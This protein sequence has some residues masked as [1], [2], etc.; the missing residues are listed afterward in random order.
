MAREGLDAFDGL[1]RDQAFDVAMRDVP[2][3]RMSE[4]EEIAGTVAWL[5]SSDALGVTGQA[6]DHNNGAFMI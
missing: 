6:I 5:L 4:P 3:R 1:T 2:L